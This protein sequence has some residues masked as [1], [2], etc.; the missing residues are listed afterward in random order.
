[1]DELQSAQSSLS[2]AL[3]RSRAGED[4][5]LAQRVR[6]LGEQLARMLI[7]LLRLTRV[8]QPSN[9]AFDAPV[10]E[11]GK[12]LEAL[13]QILGSVH[14]VTVEDQVYVN[15]VRIRDDGAKGGPRELGAELRRHNVGGLS[16]H[17]AL[18]DDQ[19]RFLVGALAAEGTTRRALAEGLEGA[20]LT[21]VELQG[22]YKFRSSVAGELEQRRDPGEVVER[23]LFLA[24]E[25]WNNLAAGRALNPL[26][27]RHAVMEAHDAGIEA[28]PFWLLPADRPAHVVH[29]VQ[30]TAVTLLLAK[31]ARLPL[32]LLHDLGIAAMLHDAGYLAPGP[33]SSQGGLAPHAVDG[34]RLMLRQRG[35]SEAKLRRVRAV[36]DHHADHSDPSGRPAAAAAVLRVAEDY[37]NGVRLFGAKVS[38]AGILGAMLAAAGRVYHPALPQLL[39]N[40]LGAHPPGTVVELET[41]RIGR[42]ACPARGRELWDR[43]LVA[44]LDPQTRAPSG[45]YA[46]LARGGAVKRLYAG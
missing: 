21:S 28:P 31:A 38:R 2:R 42:V 45:E 35:F 46:D 23:L 39:V 15:D 6:E 8:H 9:R 14:L 34:A 5:E 16:L 12:A 24:T 19:I 17:G 10:A 13:V 1:M 30:V 36:L 22:I 25:T 11:F 43:P 40:V 4:R 44:L 26:P 37:V 33:S 7:G 41:G 29:A 20:A 27:I 3:G 32:G 18:K